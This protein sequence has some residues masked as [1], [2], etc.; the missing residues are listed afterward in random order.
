MFRTFLFTLVLA[1]GLQAE[2]LNPDT[3]AN[4]QVPSGHVAFLKVEAA[5]TQNYICLP[6]ANGLA[7]KFQ[8][9]Q[10]TLYVKAPWVSDAPQQI[11][12]HFLSPNTAEAGDPARATW[13]SSIDSSAVW[14]VKIQESSDAG[15][16]AAGAIPWFLLKTA[17]SRKGPGGG[18]VLAQT[19]YIQRVNTTG[20]VMP[21]GSCPEAGALQF[22]PYTADY[23][24]YRATETQ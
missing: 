4:L 23:V 22:V 8:A 6:G 7:W 9:P 13:Q 15:F 12:T 11:A 20:G 14:A 5:G 24:F 2:S 18:G 3:P 17:G 1:A 16:V 10:A 19:T 21:A